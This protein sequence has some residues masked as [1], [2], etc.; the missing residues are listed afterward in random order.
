MIAYK[1]RFFTPIL[2]LSI[3]FS[4]LRAQ[5]N[6]T[7]VI[8][9]P[10]AEALFLRNNL[11]LL[12]SRFSIGAAQAAVLQ[13]QLWTNPN[14]ALEQNV[15][16]QFTGRY[17]DVSS[18]GNTGVQI[19]QLFL[20]AGKRDKQTRLAEINN[21]IAEDSFY[22]LLR[23]LKYELRSDFFDLF[24]MRKS[25]GFYN[26]SITSIERTVAST[27]SVYQKRGIVLSEVLRLKSLLFSLKKERLDL[28]SQIN[29]KELD[30][31]V[32]LHDS[33]FVNKII[34]PRVDSEKLETF[35]PGTLFK[36]DILTTAMK[37]R[38]DYSLAEANV[39]Y[40]ETNLSLQRAMGIPD[41]TLGGLWSRAGSYI[42]NYYAVTVSVDLPV[43]N[44]NQGNV[45][46]SQNTLEA[47]KRIRDAILENIQ[48]D[49]ATSYNK[50]VQM[51]T[52]Y[53]SFDRGFT[54]EYKQLVDGMIANYEKRN[55]SIIEF[56]D[57]FESYRTSMVQVVQLQNGRADVFEGLNYAVGADVFNP[58]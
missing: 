4:L 15:Y 18:N 46:V 26:E 2:V 10:A 41:I 12:A 35:H 13:A 17:F 37:N 16:N 33:T 52:T 38:P 31:H 19:Q 23:S 42:P 40:E 22:G 9:L 56:T 8:S 5:S 21:R 30:L 11:Q 24:Y 7:V 51:D 34:A 48:K 57:F 1:K 32:L 14:I 20:L 50:A 29:D 44:R 43:F 45:Q 25:L 28:S 39:T 53:K 55:I 3:F 36:Q 6:D 47:N 27:E 58:Y 54:S 49:V